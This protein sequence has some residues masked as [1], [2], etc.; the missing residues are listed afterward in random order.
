MVWRN[1]TAFT[2]QQPPWWWFTDWPSN[3]NEWM[4]YFISYKFAVLAKRK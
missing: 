1:F 3:H 4:N 2:E